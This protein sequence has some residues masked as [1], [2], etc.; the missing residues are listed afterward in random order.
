[1]YV[2]MAH[3]RKDALEEIQ[4]D[5]FSGSQ[6][7]EMTMEMHRQLKLGARITNMEGLDLSKKVINQPKI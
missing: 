5:H 6:T 1:M 7:N 2:F 3:K 4:R